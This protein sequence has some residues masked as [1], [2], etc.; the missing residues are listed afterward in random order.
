VL[1]KACEVVNN[2]V[3]VSKNV[4]ARNYNIVYEFVENLTHVM[5]T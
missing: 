1:N 2:T 4:I 3:E 5:E